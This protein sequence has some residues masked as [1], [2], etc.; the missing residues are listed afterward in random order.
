M[1]TMVVRVFFCKLIRY[2]AQRR[3]KS[4]QE[5]YG[6]MPVYCPACHTDSLR[7]GS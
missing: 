5:Q 3:K 7:I 1:T 6:D 2:A 4:K